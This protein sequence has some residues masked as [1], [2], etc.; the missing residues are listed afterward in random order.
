MN[1]LAVISLVTALLAWVSIRFVL[2]VPALRQTMWPVWMLH[3]LSIVLFSIWTVTALVLFPDAILSAGGVCAIITLASF[4]LFLIVYL[5][6]LRMPPTEGRPEIGSPLPHFLVTV[7]EG[8]QVT[9]RELLGQGPSMIVFF[10][11]FWCLSCT[12]ELMGL[13]KVREALRKKGGD[14]LAISA[15]KL[16]IFLMGRK[17]N[18]NVPCKLACDPGAEAITALHLL[19]AN[20]AKVGKK[21]AIPSNILIDSEGIVRWTHYANIVMDRPDPRLVM[22]KVAALR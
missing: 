1:T 11:G 7:D 19:Q 5:V 22:E 10:R 15:D 17:R 14:I 8:I 6:A 18:P 12:D 16:P 9:P 4:V 20:M 13:A 21:V 3:G 2:K